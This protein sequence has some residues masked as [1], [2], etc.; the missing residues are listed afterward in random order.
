MLHA[1]S[2]SNPRWVKPKI[3]KT[4]MGNSMGKG[5]QCDADSVSSRMQS[6]YQLVLHGWGV[7]ETTSCCCCLGLTLRLGSIMQKCSRSWWNTTLDSGCIW[8]AHSH[9]AID[10]Q[11]ALQCTICIS[12][13]V[14][15]G[16]GTG[17]ERF[18]SLGSDA[19][20]RTACSHYF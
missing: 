18:Q 7:C 20:S 19:T 17:F 15:L 11:T 5:V 16:T 6:V 9:V 3:G 1:T 2:S 4:H 14:V 10:G 12:V 8:C 13:V